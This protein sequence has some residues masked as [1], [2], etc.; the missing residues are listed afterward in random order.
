VTE[1]V[2]V[3]IDGSDQAQAAFEYVLAEFEPTTLTVLSVI[4]PAEAATARTLGGPY[5]SPLTLPGT[6]EEWFE[7]AETTARERVT[8]AADR[9]RERGIDAEAVVEIG[10]PA[11]VIRQYA[12]EH[13]CDH[14]VMGSHGRT[15]LERVLLGSV[16]ETVLRRADCPV[17]VVR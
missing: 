7:A 11:E 2:L 1:H 10:R 3:P 4:D 9:A 14:V 13:D 5:E 16:A 12:A 8:A 17:T 6:S 15:G